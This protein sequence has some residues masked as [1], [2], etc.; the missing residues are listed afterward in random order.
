VKLE[1]ENN[2]VCYS[3]R[4]VEGPESNTQTQDRPT[5]ETL[6]VFRVGLLWLGIDVRHVREVA[7]AVAPSVPLPDTAGVAG[8]IV[9]RGESTAV[10]D[11]RRVL[12]LAC[13]APDRRARMIAVRH[14][15]ATVCLLV[16]QIEGLRDV[17][18]AHLEAPPSIMVDVD[19][20]WLEYV[21]RFGNGR[22]V[23]VINVERIL[24]KASLEGKK[25]P[26][27]AP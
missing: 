9:L 24:S 23:G 25:D 21:M 17:S 7:R 20:Q 12:G 13:E 4:V 3:S 16:D 6:I 14:N 8:V 22:L 11:V 5:P 15:E 1:V 26:S 2:P 27:N 10:V 19:A 18:D